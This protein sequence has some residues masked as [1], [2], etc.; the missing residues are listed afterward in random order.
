MTPRLVKVNPFLTNELFDL[1]VSSPHPKR[2]G[3]FLNLSFTGGGGVIFFTAYGGGEFI[4]EG[5]PVMNHLG[6]GDISGIQLLLFT[7]NLLL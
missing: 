1:I 7:N 4:W 2:G 3:F 6:G 5:N